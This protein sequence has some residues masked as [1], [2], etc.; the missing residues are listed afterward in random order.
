MK[1]KS[2]RE[3]SKTVTELSSAFASSINAGDPD[4]ATACFARNACLI[5]PDATA[6][7]SRSHIRL[8]LVQMVIQRVEI[9]IEMSSPIVAGD[10]VLALERWQ[11]RTEGADGVARRQALHPVLVLRKI[12][13][14]WKFTIAAPWRFG[15]AGV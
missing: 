13:G 2:A 11:L 6:V 7:H 5:T 10:I 15:D 4:A 8:V 1:L 14:D 3:P 9:E 12:E